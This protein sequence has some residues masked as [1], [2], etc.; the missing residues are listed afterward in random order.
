MIN[1]LAIIE[2]IPVLNLLPILED[3]AQ[4][5]PQSYAAMSDEDKQAIATGLLKLLAKQGK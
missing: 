4:R 2:K 3:V 5:I 1:L